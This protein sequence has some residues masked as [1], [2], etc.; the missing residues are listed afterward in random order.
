MENNKYDYDSTEP[1]SVEDSIPEYSKN[2]IKE[3]T[4][5]SGSLDAGF[6]DKDA[7]KSDLALPSKQGE[8]SQPEIDSKKY[9]IDK[10]IRKIIKARIIND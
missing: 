6:D 8:Y 3:E 5:L 7:T 2:L 1:S 4:F 10:P 9:G